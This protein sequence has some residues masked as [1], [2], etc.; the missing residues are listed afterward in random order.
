MIGHALA[1]GPRASAR[2]AWDRWIAAGFAIGSACFFIGPFPGF[3][4]LI[5]I[6]RNK[7]LILK[8]GY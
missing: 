3:V 1:L 5:E 8:S 2:L 7:N 6:S 4:Q